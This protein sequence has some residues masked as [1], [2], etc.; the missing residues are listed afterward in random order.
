ML[1]SIPLSASPI[2]HIW[3]RTMLP[4]FSINNNTSVF[5]S[6]T[7]FLLWRNKANA[8]TVCVWLGVICIVILHNGVRSGHFHCVICVWVCVNC[9]RPPLVVVHQRQ[10]SRSHYHFGAF[11]DQTLAARRESRCHQRPVVLNSCSIKT[12]RNSATFSEWSWITVKQEG[13]NAVATKHDHSAKQNT[14]S[15]SSRQS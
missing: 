10:Q 2:D 1:S 12:L 15:S 5:S 3:W 11:C 4:E 8:L 7:C 6:S 14:S 9:V 13:L